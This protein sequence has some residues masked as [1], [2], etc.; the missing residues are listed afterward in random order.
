MPPDNSHLKLKSVFASVRTGPKKLPHSGRRLQMP[1]FDNP[2]NL[3]VMRRSIAGCF[4]ADLEQKRAVRRL[5][6]I[7]FSAWSTQT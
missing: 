2:R 7:C 4:A 3:Y 5:K 6:L 1:I